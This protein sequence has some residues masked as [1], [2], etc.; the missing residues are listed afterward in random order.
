MIIIIYSLIQIVYS[1]PSSTFRSV[2]KGHTYSASHHTRL[3]GYQPVN[4]TDKNPFHKIDNLFRK[5]TNKYGGEEISGVNW[6]VGWDQG[7]LFYFG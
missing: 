7:W 5:E 6:S 1:I 3:Q 2:F 4:N